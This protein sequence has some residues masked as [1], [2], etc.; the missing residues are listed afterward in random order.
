M[1]SNAWRL[2]AA[3]GLA[4][5]FSHAVAQDGRLAPNAPKD[6]IVRSDSPDKAHAALAPYIARARASYP[7]AKARWLAGLPRSQSFFVTVPLHDARDNEEIVFVLV[8]RAADGNVTGLLASDIVRVQGYRRGQPLTIPESALIDW[9]ITKPDGSE[10][11]NL[12]GKFM[13]SHGDF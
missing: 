7:Q 2:A 6:K 3:A 13:E 11:G 9:L 8:Q 4:V 10:E 5:A 12:V 1:G